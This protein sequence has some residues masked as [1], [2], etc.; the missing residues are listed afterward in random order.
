MFKQGLHYS[1]LVIVYIVLT[2]AASARIIYLDQINGDDNNSGLSP[3]EPVQQFSK[4]QELFEEGD[5]IRVTGDLAPFVSNVDINMQGSFDPDFQTQDLENTPSIIDGQGIER[6]I[7]VFSVND[8]VLDCTLGGFIVRNGNA[9]EEVEGPGQG[10]G[11]YAR[12]VNLRLGFMSFEN[13][14]AY[15]VDDFLLP[16]Q[17]GCG[18]GLF[19]SGSVLEISDSRFVNNKA[20][21]VPQRGF[22]KGEERLA[23][24]VPPDFFGLGG[25][26]YWDMQ[27]GPSNTIHLLQRTIFQANIA[28]FA[29]QISDF[30]DEKTVGAGGAAHLTTSDATIETGTTL[31]VTMTDVQ[32]D[33]NIAN[34][35]PG[36]DGFGGAISID[37]R[38]LPPIN[39]ASE[40][41]INAV[42]QNNIAQKGDG[43]PVEGTGGQGGAIY[44]I[45]DTPTLSN[46]TFPE[47]VF[48][49]S[50]FSAN[51]GSKG[52]GASFGIGG[53]IAVKDI[54]RIN[55]LSSMLKENIASEG[56]GAG[57]GGGA[58][59]L[60]SSFFVQQSDFWGNRA[61]SEPEV[62][63]FANLFGDGGAIFHRV[64]DDNDGGSIYNS[65]FI[66]NRAIV[67][68]VL[69]PPSERGPVF[70]GKGEDLYFDRPSLNQETASRGFFLIPFS[71]QAFGSTFVA[72]P[73]AETTSIYTEEGL[74]YFI[75][76]IFSNYSAAVSNDI[77]EGTFNYNLMD[78]NTGGVLNPGSG[79]DLSQGNIF[80]GNANLIL[81]VDSGVYLIGPF[82]DA[83]DAGRE[84]LGLN[85][86]LL[87][88]RIGR[89]RPIGEGF[90]MGYNEFLGTPAS[91]TLED[92]LAQ[93]KGEGGSYGDINNDDITDSADVMFFLGLDN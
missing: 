46:S 90:D 87:V 76:N 85:Q 58:D 64:N 9:T 36:G 41:Y 57:R 86:N 88:D 24:P 65:G 81:D 62:Q 4:A 27:G 71:N 33:G 31:G 40:I 37:F 42:F 26:L 10:G 3:A 15:E 60:N 45:G 28:L 11:L 56:G 67:K 70:E 29:Q 32:F 16:E 79:Y 51:V 84:F 19:S 73:D 1:L 43:V 39:S 17:M 89:M 92:I 20:V 91:V 22:A 53:A 63:F 35:V 69:V 12:D 47:V 21:F 18:G 14:I 38:S 23:L 93:I 61:L 25:A 50:T 80:N 72:A 75:N 34:C 6:P 44:F 77:G 55:I 54:T 68:P 2:N 48:E 30:N 52:S 59:I 49:N 8:Q 7:S 83:I 78:G 66:D 5:E 74:F 82:S 13:N